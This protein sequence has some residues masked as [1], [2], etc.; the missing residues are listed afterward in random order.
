MHIQFERS[1]KLVSKVKSCLGFT[2]QACDLNFEDVYGSI[3]KGYIEAHHLV[4]QPQLARVGFAMM[5]DAARGAT[6][7]QTTP[8][9]SRVLER[10]HGRIAL[11]SDV[12]N[13]G[14]DRWLT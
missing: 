2:C 9:W 8:A 11:A 12:P 10:L 7:V 4:L 3:G 6:M 14:D 1:R 5:E 13:R